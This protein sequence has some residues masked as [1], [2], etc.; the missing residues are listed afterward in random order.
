[1]L[2]KQNKPMTTITF[3]DAQ[4]INSEQEAIEVVFVYNVNDSTQTQSVHIV[5][6][7]NSWGLT[8]PEKF[9]YIQTL[10]TGTVAYMKDFWETHE[11]LPNDK[12]QLNSQSDFPPYQ[13]G[14]TA[15]EGYKLELN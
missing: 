9:E 11:A 4:L 1:M 8:E 5:G 7:E 12:K 2:N 13:P 6:S 3:I 14:K 10:F 15:W